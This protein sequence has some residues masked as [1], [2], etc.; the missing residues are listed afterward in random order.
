MSACWTVLR[1]C[2]HRYGVMCNA[3]QKDHFCYEETK[4][5]I[6]VDRVSVALQVPA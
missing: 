4:D 2:T 1:T 5:K 6:L 3:H